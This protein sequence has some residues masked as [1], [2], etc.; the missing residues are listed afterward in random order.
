MLFTRLFVRVGLAWNYS[1][2]LMLLQSAFGVVGECSRSLWL[3]GLVSVRDTSRVV[4]NG[5]IVYSTTAV[6]LGHAIIRFVFYLSRSD[7][8]GAI[9]L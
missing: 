8:D 6:I 1:R 9:H 4:N 2:L 5:R 3:D 7:G